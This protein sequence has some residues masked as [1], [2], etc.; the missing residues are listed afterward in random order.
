MSSG[1]VHANIAKVTA[2]VSSVALLYPES[3]QKAAFALGML[4][5]VLITPD[6]DL[7]GITYEERRMLD[8]NEKIGNLWM[9]F[10]KPYS[11]L[12]KHRGIS[13][14]LVLGTLTRLPYG[15]LLLLPLWQ[16]SRL[17]F[18]LNVEPLLLYIFAGWT[19]Q[20]AIH[21]V[22]DIIYSANKERKNKFSKRRQ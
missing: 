12:F 16:L 17:V 20:D 22:T 21:I 6:L 7:P 1:R 2:H 11:K 8:I 15:L 3:P 19:L 14:W 4:V 18:S 13:H 5:G 9:L 10:T